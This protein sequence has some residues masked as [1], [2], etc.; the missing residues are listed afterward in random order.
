MIR[1]GYRFKTFERTMAAGEALD[2]GKVGLIEF[3][4]PVRIK[5]TA[6][7][8]AV[9]FIPKGP[10][11]DPGRPTVKFPQTAREIVE[12]TEPDRLPAA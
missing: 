6:P 4:A 12:A 3:H 7:E 11:T 1:A 9:R 2:L 10:P 5:V 8:D